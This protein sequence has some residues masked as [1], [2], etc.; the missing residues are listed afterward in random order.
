MG[1]DGETPVTQLLQAI[2]SG[3]EIARERLFDLL[4][5]ELRTVARS[6]MAKGPAAGTLQATALVNEAY[7]RLLGREI[8]S[9]ENRRHFFFTAARAMRDVLVEQARRRAAKRRGGDLKRVGL[10]GLELSLETPEEELLAMDAAL[11]KLEADDARQ[12]DIVRLRFFAGL[13]EEEI[14]DALD[15]SKRTVSRDWGKAR[16]RLALLLNP[17]D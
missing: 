16:A 11:E 4:Y 7:L 8:P 3:D 9:W 14:A 1:A 6:Q 17:A 5:D 10:E 15:V 13:S 12:A 2:G